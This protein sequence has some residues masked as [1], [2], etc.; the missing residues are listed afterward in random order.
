L[1]KIFVF[2]FLFLLNFYSFGFQPVIITNDDYEICLFRNTVSYFE[3]SS[4]SLKISKIS[5]GDGKTHVLKESNSD[6]L[7]KMI[8]R[9][10]EET[11]TTVY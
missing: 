3:D 2:A 6:C 10:P 4:A 11:E 1:N 5:K 9:I 7:L 8:T